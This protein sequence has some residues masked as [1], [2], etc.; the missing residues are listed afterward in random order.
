VS[1]TGP[2]TDSKFERGLSILADL[3]PSPSLNFDS[4]E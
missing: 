4:L 2:L 1:L 3:L